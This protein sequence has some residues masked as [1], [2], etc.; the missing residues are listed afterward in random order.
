MRRTAAGA[1]I[2]LAEPRARLVFSAHGTPLEYLRR[3][4]RY[5]AFV[6]EFCAAVARELGVR[7]Y[8]IGYQNHEGESGIAW[9]EPAIGRVIADL[10]ADAV[11][12]DPVSFMHEQSETLAELDLRLRGEAEARGLRFYR[13][14]I[15]WDAPVFIDTL[16][17]LVEA[18]IAPSPAAAMPV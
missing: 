18:R 4:S 1:G 14:P 2:S 9:T 13:V 11:V 17:N 16:A 5:I 3:G 15:P 10:D 12:V 6:E 8:V 7:E